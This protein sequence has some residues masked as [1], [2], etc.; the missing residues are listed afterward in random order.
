MAASY[1][2]HDSPLWHM[3]NHHY[4][5]CVHSILRARWKGCCD[6]PYGKVHGANMGLTWVLSAPDGPHIGPMNL[7][8]SDMLVSMSL[9]VS[10]HVAT[11]SKTIKCTR[12][13]RVAKLWPWMW[14][15]TYTFTFTYSQIPRISYKRTLE[16]LW[17][18]IRI[19][20][21]KAVRNLSW[22]SYCFNETFPGTHIC[23]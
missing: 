16:A 17:R 10:A 20:G 13:W 3:P 21:C 4:V 11:W 12:T 1:S 18:L 5:V 2:L 22:H 7:A 19:W 9:S 8:I 15:F 6:I 23:Q 14:C